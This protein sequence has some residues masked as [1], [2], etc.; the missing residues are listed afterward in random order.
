MTRWYKYLKIAGEYWFDN[1]NNIHDADGDNGDI[2]HDMVVV[3]YLLN[4]LGFDLH[5]TPYNIQ[6]AQN[7]LYYLVQNGDYK[8]EDYIKWMKQHNIE[9][10][11][12]HLLD[13]FKFK[14]PQR[15]NIDKVY[16]GFEQPRE[17]A[18]KNLGWVRIEGNF[19]QVHHLNE[20]IAYNI[21]QNLYEVYD[22]NATERIYNIEIDFPKHQIIKG[23]T[24]D[25]LET[26]EVINR[27]NQLDDYLIP[28]RRNIDSPYK[29]E[30]D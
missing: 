1:N 5:E 29:Y 9:L 3:Q 18:I 30:G 10:H 2:N 23:V 11:N 19:I 21:A 14:N 15:I 13:Y 27:L 28:K 24:F 7:I 17:Y 16:E 12:T 6:D 20:N 26:G 4:D 8:V 25:D 22:E